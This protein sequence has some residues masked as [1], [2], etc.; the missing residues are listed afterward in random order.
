MKLSQRVTFCGAVCALAVLILLA[1]YFPYATYALAA[2]AGIVL[3]PAAL[4]LGTRYGL[5]CYVVTALLAA[6]ITPDPEAKVLYVLFFG[7][8]PCLQLRLNLMFNRVLSLVIKELVFNA[9]VLGGYWFLFNVIGLPA[10]AFTIGDVY[11]PIVFWIAANAVFVVYDIA[12]CRVTA[13]YRV[14]LHPLVRMYFK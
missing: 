13:M 2:L 12:L 4:E 9:A 7:Y 8:Y 10:D 6:L 1:S 5:L 14:R 3:I 11:L